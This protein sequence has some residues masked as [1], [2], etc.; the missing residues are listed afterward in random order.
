M[1]WQYFEINTTKYLN[2]TYGNSSLTFEH[3]G[4]FDSSK[5]DIYVYRDEVNIFNIEC[6]FKNS[7]SSQFVLLEDPSNKTF[8]FSS[9]NMSSED[10]AAELIVHVN[11]NYDYYSK[12]TSGNRRNNKLICDQ[13]IINNYVVKNLR[14][15]FTRDF[16]CQLKHVVEYSFSLICAIYLHKKRYP[17][18][19]KLFNI[20]EIKS[21]W[22][23][24]VC[25]TE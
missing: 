7:Q 22:F 13:D 14:R 17:L 16:T 19:L 4:G 25:E 18:D 11:Q 20:R 10:D 9:K 2:A 24:R 12:K 21:P 23:N 5:P 6:K 1:D 15:K 3:E 8:T